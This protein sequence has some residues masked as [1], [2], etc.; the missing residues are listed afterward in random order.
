MVAAVAEVSV[1][2]TRG[3]VTVHDFWLPLDP[4]IAVQPDNVVAQTES[5]IVYGL[6]RAL[7]ERI[8]IVDGAVQQSHILPY[9][10]ARR[11]DTSQ[12]HIR[13][14]AKPERPTRAGPI[15]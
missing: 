3:K 9:R 1:D 10:G 7:T 6:G 2:R 11:D 12:L 8:T 15:G 5:S 4:G 14:I 13:P